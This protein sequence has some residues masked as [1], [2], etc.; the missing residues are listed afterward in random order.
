MQSG[1]VNH[2]V[3]LFESGYALTPIALTTP[4]DVCLQRVNKRR[5]ARDPDRG[6]VDPYNATEKY[7][8]VVRATSRL[9]SAGVPVLRLDCAA[10]LV[11]LRKQLRR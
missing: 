7:K 4:L 10:A 1:D 11:F 6:S 5:H 8:C 9:E 2:V 3:D